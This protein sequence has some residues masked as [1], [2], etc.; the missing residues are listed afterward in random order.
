MHHVELFVNVLVF[1][2]ETSAKRIVAMLLKHLFHCFLYLLQ[3]LYSPFSSSDIIK[4]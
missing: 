3:L 1:I 4:N 2:L